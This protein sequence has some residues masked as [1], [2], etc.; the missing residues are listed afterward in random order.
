M[1]ALDLVADLPL[2][3]DPA[4]GPIE[5]LRRMLVGWMPEFFRPMECHAVVSGEAFDWPA[6]PGLQAGEDPWPGEVADGGPVT[7]TEGPAALS[8]GIL[9]RL[10][11]GDRYAIR[12]LGAL[13]FLEPDVAPQ[14]GWYGR[15]T[16]GDSKGLL[17][18]AYIQFHWNQSWRELRLSFPALG[19]PL[20]GQLPRVGPDG[21]G[22]GVQGPETVAFNRQ[23]LIEAFVRCADVLGY[24]RGDIRWSVEAESDTPEATREEIAT[25]L[26]QTTG[27][28]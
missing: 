28:P 2:T 23:N 1:Q 24:A 5:A 17:A 26:Q 14:P 9:E 21:R 8:M 22:A 20:S 7:R 4:G 16:D 6:S 10:P 19:Y 13:K 25:L 18:V 27:R 12:L 15:A 11:S 3:T